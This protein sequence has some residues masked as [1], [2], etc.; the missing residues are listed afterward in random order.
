[1]GM[2]SPLCHPSI[3]TAACQCSKLNFKTFFSVTLAVVTKGH[4]INLY[5]LEDVQNLASKADTCH[6]L[7]LIPNHVLFSTQ[8]LGAISFLNKASLIACSP[9]T[10]TL[11]MWVGV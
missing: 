8:S 5:Q 11:S 10:R 7:A 1:M 9:S 3:Q 4:T 6:D 2:P